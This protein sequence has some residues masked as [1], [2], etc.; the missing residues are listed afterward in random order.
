MFAC[1]HEGVVGGLRFKP[2]LTH[3]TCTHMPG[4][5]ASEDGSVIWTSHK[6]NHIYQ[7]W[8]I[9]NQFCSILDPRWELSYRITAVSNIESNL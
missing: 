1:A 2:L 5:P 4:P 6:L 7:H 8:H 9:E 3:C